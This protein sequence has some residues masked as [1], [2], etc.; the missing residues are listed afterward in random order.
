M[1]INMKHPNNAITNII[2]EL[3]LPHR[4]CIVDFLGMVDR[5]KK[6]SQLRFA[7][8]RYT[9]FSEHKLHKKGDLPSF[10]GKLQVLDIVQQSWSTSLRL[11]V[12]VLSLPQQHST[13][14]VRLPT[15]LEQKEGPAFHKRRTWISL[16]NLTLTVIDINS[17]WH[18]TK[19]LPMTIKTMMVSG[20]PVYI[21]VDLLKQ[22]TLRI[23]PR[24]IG[25]DVKHN[26]PYP[27]LY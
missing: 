21:L 5:T 27:P 6:S 26:Q 10:Q 9:L 2:K 12:S 11:M 25:F 16:D 22:G 8:G 23:P 20:L 17:G 19:C 3:Q 1:H 15:D 7:D 14:S 4:N 13:H 24:G 18:E